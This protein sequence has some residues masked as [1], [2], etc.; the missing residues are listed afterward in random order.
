SANPLSLETND[1]P[2]LDSSLPAEAEE[3]TDLD[4]HPEIKRQETLLQ[5]SR[6]DADLASNQ[7]LP[8]LDLALNLSQDYG[9]AVYGLSKA[10]SEAG[11]LFEFP[12][13]SRSAT[14]RTSQMRALVLK[15]D[16]QVSLARSRVENAVTDAKAALRL[17]RDRAGISNQE[18]SLSRTL[19]QMENKRFLNGDS[20]L[21]LLNLREQNF[22][23]AEIRQIE[24][25]SDLRRSQNELNVALGR[26]EF[27]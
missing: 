2:A 1:L 8:K 5:Q 9:N 19:V 26:L 25:F 20:N 15:Q 16:A 10:R 24:A 4:Q 7:F 12:I 14:A 13:P 17:A 11:V 3:K 27:D 21:L 23:E 6:L 18:L 22:A